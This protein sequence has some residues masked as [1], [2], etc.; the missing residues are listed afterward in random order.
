MSETTPDALFG[1]DVDRAKD[2]LEWLWDHRDEIAHVA[3]TLPSLLDS[4]GNSITAAGGGAHTAADLLIGTPER[5]GAKGLA[6]VAAKT[7]R[8]CEK[9]LAELHEL[10][11]D[12]ADR[13]D[14]IN[15][16]GVGTV[17]DQAAGKLRD[18]SARV[19][20]VADGMHGVAST[21]TQ[22]GGS[23]GEAAGGLRNAGDHLTDTGTTLRSLL[24]DTPTAAR[25]TTTTR[26]RPKPAPKAAPKAA[27]AGSVG[28]IGE[29]LEQSD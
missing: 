3:E 24:A 18:G 9:E 28:S 13:L 6:E 19:D 25:T 5:P 16:P 7:L 23:L 29:L 20:R 26:A 27:A 17:F 4:A 2:A 8:S 21:L 10:L 12:L 11:D 14:A 22:L 15:L 1:V